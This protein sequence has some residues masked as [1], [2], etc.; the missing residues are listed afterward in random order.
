MAAGLLAEMGATVVRIDRPSTKPGSLPG[1]L[2][3]LGVRDR[4]VVELD[5]KA[6]DDLATARSL[7]TG[8]DVLIE[9]FRPGVAERLGIGPEQ[10]MAANPRL[11]YVRV[12]GWGQTGPYAAM[13]GHDINYI[14]LAGVLAAIGTS[15]PV[16]PLNLVGDYGGG[17]MF[18]VVGALAGIVE[19][20]R[21]GRGGVVDVA[22]IDGASRLLG[23]IRDLLDVG[24]WTERRGANLLDGGA[25]FYRTYRTSDGRFVAVGALEPRFYAEL[26]AGLG[27]DPGELPDRFDPDT[28]PDL[29][30]RFAEVFAGRT[31]AH[32]AEVFDGTDA[33][34][35]PVLSMSEVP[36]HPHNAA[37]G[38]L[39]DTPQGPV[40]APAPRFTSEQGTSG[41]RGEGPHAGPSGGPPAVSDTLEA[42]GVPRTAIDELIVRGA[43]YR[44]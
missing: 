39:T 3:R 18:A 36:S 27:L 43:A 32:W 38:L 28:W 37:R 13:A 34:V 24:M 40:A 9:G 14:G 2:D 31:A 17:A 21:T 30:R 41:A 10:A 33:C 23:P 7:V 12:T 1:G 16:P 22:M 26:I 44:V 8:A 29:H 6:A 19:R 25:P 11:V 20:G 42:L 4:L 35:T 15:E 5:L